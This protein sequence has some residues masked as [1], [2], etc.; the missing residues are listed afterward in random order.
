MK[1]RL[2]QETV[3]YDGAMELLDCGRCKIYELCKSGELVSTT[4]AG[5]K[6][7]YIYSIEEYSDKVREEAKKE[8]DRRRVS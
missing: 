7:I 5:K 4:H 8:A 1:S 2:I 6:R 3:T